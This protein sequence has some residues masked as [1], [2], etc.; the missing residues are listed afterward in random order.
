M[1]KNNKTL[2]WAMARYEENP[3]LFPRHDN[4]W[5]SKYVFNCAMVDLGSEIHYVYRAIGDDMVSRLGYAASTDGY[6]IKERLDYPILSP[7]NSLEKRGCEDPRI[8]VM[9]DKC[10]MTYT[11]YSDIPQIAITTI[12]VDDFLGRRWSWSERI[13]PFQT[14]T[15]KNAVIFPRKMRG[16]YVMLHRIDPNVYIA[17]SRD[18]R[19]WEN[20]KII[21]KPREGLWDS[22]KIGAAGPPMEIDDGWLQI[23]HGVDQNMTY[24]LGAVVLDKKK[25]EKVLYRTKDPFLEPQEEYECLG[26]VP[27]VVFSCGSVI[28]ND[29]VLVSYGC[30]DTVI[31]VSTFSMEEIIK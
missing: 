6:V 9:G 23:Y 8:T 28:K 1:V 17:Y 16:S 12:S 5:E 25:P 7:S 21:L 22:R 3:I 13:Y 26:Y 15:N 4:R 30:A 24:R 18:L 20:S 2:I 27:N 31:G 29:K 11:A 19:L 14:T 10:I